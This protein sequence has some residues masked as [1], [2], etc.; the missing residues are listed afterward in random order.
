MKKI[1]SLIYILFIFAHANAQ[2][3]Q[4]KFGYLFK[5]DKFD[6]TGGSGNLFLIGSKPVSTKLTVGSFTYDNNPIVIVKN[7][8]ISTPTYTPK[9]ISSKLK[10]TT[11]RNGDTLFINFWDIQKPDPKASISQFV[12]IDD[13]GKDFAF[14]ITKWQTSPFFKGEF[15]DV[16][17]R[18]RQF[19][20]TNLPF[21]ILTKS[22][23]LES[24][25]LNAN[26][27]YMY[28]AGHT[29]LFK[30]QFIENRNRYFA[31][32]PYLGL[33]S[34]DNGVSG[35]KEF[36]INYG[37]NAA[38]GLQGFNITVAYGFQQGFKE[39]TKDVQPYIG[40][41]IGFKLLETFTPEIKKKE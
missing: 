14:V 9:E 37:A 21:R 18:F 41:G 30:S 22:G 20:A 4:Y 19:M 15:F 3:M 31:Y 40:L 29:R 24:D 1:M 39:G 35:K 27:A 13:N 36:G 26:V 25:F 6:N 5:T 2:D 17:F 8:D 11:T 33:S 34:I 10:G 28:V 12:N 32:G 7:L 38:I 16:P 23:D